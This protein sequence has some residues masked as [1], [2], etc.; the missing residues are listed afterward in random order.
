MSDQRK[1][2]RERPDDVAE[3]VRIIGADEAADVLD[4][5]EVQRRLGA[6]EMRRGDRP[7][8]PAAGGPPPALRFPLDSSADLDQARRPGT[9]AAGQRQVAPG[10]SHWSESAPQEVPHMSPHDPYEGDEADTWSAFGGAGP[11]WRD[12]EPGGDRPPR[13][14]Q[15]G[16]QP[17]E[18]LVFDDYQEP[19]AGRSVFDAGGAPGPPAPGPGAQGYRHDTYEDDYR[20][21]GYTDQGYTDQGYMDRGY[22]GRSYGDQGYS[23]RVTGTRFDT[24]Y[25]D[26]YADDS[27]TATAPPVQPYEPP[28]EPPGSARARPKA[29]RRQPAP[30]RSEGG[31]RDMSKAML[32]GGGLIVV[33]LALFQIDPLAVAL[34]VTALLGVASLEYF[35]ATQRAGFDPLMPVGV[36]ATVVM[37]L[38]AFYYGEQALPLVLVLAIAVCLVWYLVGAGGERPMA[39]VGATLLGIVWIG[40]LGA[41]A[42][43]LLDAPN[44][45]A[46]LVAAIVPTIGYDVGALFVGRSAGSRPLSPA[47]PNKT[48]EGLA[49]GIVLAVVAGALLGVI[50][51]HPFAFSDGLM[52]GVVAALVVP[53]GDLSESLLKRDLGIKDMG[54]VLPG[55]GGVLDRFDG[56]LFALPAIW[57]LAR[58]T[59]GFLG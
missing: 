7:P 11:R 27:Y 15:Q 29:A 30:R 25:D 14:S 19:S 39:N 22:P 32:V 3:G 47:S 58:V 50:G 20:D 55:H 5:G 36:A 26:S 4:R 24:S 13:P 53:L 54:S 52:I 45:E 37:P 38:T 16:G 59:D 35:T 46:L 23:D 48:L 9:P 31:D 33:A 6:D 21:R 17:G 8:T 51:L 41:F 43:L 34:L 18:P 12:D 28:P 57:Y 42:G 1:G 44:G 10:L 49:G 40:L 56:L 2:R